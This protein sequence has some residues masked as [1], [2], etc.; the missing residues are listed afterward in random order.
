MSDINER[1]YWEPAREIERHQLRS[2]QRQP[3]DQHDHEHST[4]RQ[5]KE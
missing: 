4:E 5:Q 3:E 2:D 1:T